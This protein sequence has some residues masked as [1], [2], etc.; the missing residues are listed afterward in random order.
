MNLSLQVHLSAKNSCEVNCTC[1]LY[2][3]VRCRLRSSI[4]FWFR[5]QVVLVCPLSQAALYKKDIPKIGPVA[6]I[7]YQNVNKNFLSYSQMYAL[8]S[9]KQW[10]STSFFDTLRINLQTVV[11]IKMLAWSNTRFCIFF[12]I[13]I[14][15]FLS[16]LWYFF[17]ILSEFFIK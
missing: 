14:T 2:Y 17:K 11:F 12:E 10:N 5:W 7:L 8:Q 15:S 13:G 4:L 3:Q 16:F 1:V 6:A 9:L